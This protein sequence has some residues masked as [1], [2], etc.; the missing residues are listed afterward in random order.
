MHDKLCS[1]CDLPMMKC[2]GIAECVMCPPEVKE[3]KKSADT[4]IIEEVKG[5]VEAKAEA[6]KPSN[7]T[8]AEILA[9]RLRGDKSKNKDKNSGLSE[10]EKAEDDILHMIGTL[11]MNGGDIQEYLSKKK[12]DR[13]WLKEAED[14]LLEA[15][16]IAAADEESPETD[17]KKPDPVAVATFVCEE[18][19]GVFVEGGDIYPPETPTPESSIGCSIGHSFLTFKNMFS[20]HHVKVEAVGSMQ[21][22]SRSKATK[23]ATSRAEAKQ[24]IAALVADGWD[25]SADSCPLCELPL[26]FNPSGHTTKRCVT[27]GPI[28]SSSSN[29][30]ISGGSFDLVATSKGSQ[31][32]VTNKM[33]TMIME[34][35]SIVEG[36]QCPTCRM[37]SMRNPQTQQ[38][39]CVA[40]EETQQSPA[41]RHPAMI[42]MQNKLK[43]DVA[44]DVTPTAMPDPPTP[45]MMYD[46]RDQYGSEKKAVDPSPSMQ[47]FQARPELLQLT[48]GEPTPAAKELRF[49]LNDP[50]PNMQAVRNRV[51]FNDPTPNMHAVRN[52]VSAA[53]AHGNDYSNIAYL[54]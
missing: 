4:M 8:Q 35:W 53:E 29:D 26:F 54:E 14:G 13:K 52:R 3:E 44:P 38:T 47:A 9:D 16:A 22:T 25:V 46:L 17:M 11:G 36:K 20:S 1:K 39:H 19:E 51:K 50:T 31:E 34:G 6:P 28:A 24:R 42:A 41:E 18:E 15:E 10:L 48:M 45:S 2:K 37:P 49:K 32:D 40:C 30:T 27:C 43:V 33:V 7:K 23:P 12:A 5:A 21:S